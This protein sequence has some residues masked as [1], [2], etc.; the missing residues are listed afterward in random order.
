MS[1]ALEKPV[2]GPNGPPDLEAATLASLAPRAGP[3]KAL[4]LLTCDLGKSRTCEETTET[5]LNN[6]IAHILS[7][8]V[9]K[10]AFNSLRSLLFTA[11]P[12]LDGCSRCFAARHSQ[13]MCLW[14]R[15]SRGQDQSRRYT[16]VLE[17]ARHFVSLPCLQ[18]GSK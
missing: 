9:C 1:P 12:L 11:Y 5:Y 3:E 2:G 16:S 7:L 18:V 13:T 6:S 4:M 14:R 15:T 10:W 8:Q 17:P